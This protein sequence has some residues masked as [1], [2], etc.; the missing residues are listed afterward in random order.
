MTQINNG[1][2]NP[3]IQPQI[4]AELGEFNPLVNPELALQTY[5]SFAAGPTRKDEREAFK[6]DQTHHLEMT[7]PDLDYEVAVQTQETLE[8]LREKAAATYGEGSLTVSSIDYRIQEAEFLQIAARF[9]AASQTDNLAELQ[10]LAEQFVRSNDQLYGKPD[11]EI[12][13]TMLFD[14]KQRYTSDDPRVQK[15]WSELEAGFSMQ[16]ADGTD[17]SVQALEIPKEAKR[18]LPELSEQ[19]KELLAAEWKLMFPA[20]VEARGLL[21]DIIAAE[22]GFESNYDLNEIKFSGKRTADLFRIAVQGLADQHQTSPFAVEESEQGTT[23]SWES[24]RQ[25]VVVGLNMIPKKWSGVRETG[26]HESMHGLK[27][28]NG[29]LSGEPAMATGVFSSKADGSFVDY[30]TYEEG[31]N[32]LGEQVV[33]MAEEDSGVVKGRYNYLLMAGLVYRGF[34]DRQVKEV[35]EKLVTI[36]RICLE[37]DFDMQKAAPEIAEQVTT[38]GVMRLF[39]GTPTNAP[40]TVD[41]HMP[42]FTKDIAYYNGRV[43][44]TEF[45][46]G[47]E[48][49]AVVVGQSAYEQAIAAGQSTTKAEQAKRNATREYFHEIFEIQAQGKIDPTEPVQYA[50][51]KA[52]YQKR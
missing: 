11:Q 26:V 18:Q 42:I 24:G 31:N 43:I 19:A 35:F 27:S 6:N 25:A 13:D 32:S 49:D 3:D 33:G 40:V 47:V 23:A 7:Y 39:R 17:V 51:A 45:W 22:Q 38:R 52:A 41:G 48:E 14:L 50:A 21:G 36:E 10:D 34:S 2:N 16:L 44:A 20:V 8:T 5:E 28:S 15:L 29:L 46:N 30:L 1:I 9:N 12:V 4:G 37:P